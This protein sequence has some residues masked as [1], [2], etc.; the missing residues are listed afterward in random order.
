MLYFK[1]AYSKNNKKFEIKVYKQKNYLS[2]KIVL[3]R[4]IN[5]PK[6]IHNVSRETLN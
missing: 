1:I 6:V 3:I 4:I 5:K 2:I